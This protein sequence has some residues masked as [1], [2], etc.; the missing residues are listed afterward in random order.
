MKE[1]L[2]NFFRHPFG[3]CLLPLYSTLLLLLYGGFCISEFRFL[4]DKEFFDAAIRDVF[5]SIAVVETPT[6]G[7]ATFIP[8]E[9]VRYRSLDEFHRENPNCCKFVPHDRVWISAW[10]ELFGKAAKSVH[11]RYMVR[12]VNEFG[13]VSSTEAV[14]QR[15]VTNCGRSL[16]IH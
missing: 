7:Y 1:A 4:S 12:Y 5:M 11:V 6:G 13:G 14:A 15:A 3:Y 2:S 10:Y 16:H 8:K 9:M